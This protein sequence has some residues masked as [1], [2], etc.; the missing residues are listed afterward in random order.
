MATKFTHKPTNYN[1]KK[2]AEKLEDL[3]ERVA[4][5]GIYVVRKNDY[6][7]WDLYDYGRGQV[8]FD[9]LPN[10]H[11]AQRICDKYNSSSRKYSIVKQRTIRNLCKEI[12]KHNMDCIYY[13]HTMQSTESYE[14]YICMKTRIQFAKDKIKKLMQDL[15]SSLA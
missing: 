1:R 14:R 2:L 9:N 3:S 7:E 15:T 10:K 5:R 8:I 4:A 13:V 6:N 12:S 11:V